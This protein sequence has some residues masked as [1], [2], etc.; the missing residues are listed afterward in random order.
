M[1][2]G[3]IIALAF[4]VVLGGYAQRQQE[5]Q[6]RERRVQAALDRVWNQV[7]DKVKGGKV[8]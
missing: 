6:E 3:W 4:G 5:A 1:L 2:V 7:G 8:N